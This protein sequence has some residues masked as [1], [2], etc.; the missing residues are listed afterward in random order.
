MVGSGV[1]VGSAKAVGSG[2][3]VEV[4]SSGV[5]VE[6]VGAVGSGVVCQHSTSHREVECGIRCRE[7]DLLG[8]QH[9]PA[10]SL[11]GDGPRNDSLPLFL[12]LFTE[13]NDFWILCDSYFPN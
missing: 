2:V 7:P 10:P 5:V 8:D 11:L 4:V 9:L 6:V 12:L 1:V 13:E 3:V